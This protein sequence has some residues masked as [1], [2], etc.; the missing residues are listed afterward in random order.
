MNILSLFRR[1]SSIL[2]RNNMCVSYSTSKIQHFQLFKYR[3]RWQSFG[4]CEHVS[5]RG[6][7]VCKYMPH[8]FPVFFLYIQWLYNF[9][10]TVYTVTVYTKTL[11][12]WK[13]TNCIYNRLYI[14]R[15]YDVYTLPQ[16]LYIQCKYTV[17]TAVYMQLYIQC[18]HIRHISDGLYIQW[19]YGIP[20]S[21]IYSCIYSP[22]LYIQ[23]IYSVY[24][25]TVYT[26]HCIYSEACIYN[27][28]TLYIHCI[29]HIQ[30]VY[31]LYIRRALV[32]TH[33]VFHVYKMKNTFLKRLS[34]LQQ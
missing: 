20:Y 3:A 33:R 26:V 12:C 13:A 4:L 15:I 14:H 18:E 34:C 29:Y 6:F 25:V 32:T 27:V 24:T 30:P 28:Y 8:A 5:I 31:T 19:L 1:K 16:C 7:L 2:I 17:Y 11:W 21:R 23:C 10:T 9:S 22:W